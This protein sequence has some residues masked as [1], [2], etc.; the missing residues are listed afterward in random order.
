M[1]REKD[2][3]RRYVTFLN[4][5]NS[6]WRCNFCKHESGGGATRIKAHLAGIGGFGIKGCERV[7]VNVRAEARE[8]LMPKKV[9][10]LSDQG[11]SEERI[12]GNARAAPN[13]TSDP[14]N[15]E[16]GT[17][18]QFPQGVP[19]LTPQTR[20]WMEEMVQAVREVDIANLPLD[21][22]TS[23]TSA[24]NPPN[25]FF[26]NSPNQLLPSFTE[27][28]TLNAQ[29]NPSAPLP[30]QNRQLLD[31]T[32]QSELPASIMPGPIASDSQLTNMATT[33]TPQH[34]N[35]PDQSFHGQC[36][37]GTGLSPPWAS[38]EIEPPIPSQPFNG[39]LI[40]EPLNSPLQIPDD[41][42]D[43]VG[44]STSEVQAALV[45]PQNQSVPHQSINNETSNNAP[46]PSQIPTCGT[47]LIGPLSLLELDVNKSAPTTS[48]PNTGS[49]FEENGALKRKF[50]RLYNREYDIKNEL[51]YVASL[52][53]KKPRM[54]VANWLANVEKLRND[55]PCT[56]AASEDC[57]PPHRQVDILMREAEDLTRHGNFLSG[58]FEA[59]EIKVSKLLEGKMVG[60]AFKRN[61]TKILEYLVGNQVSRLGIYGMG[62]VGKTTIMVH[63]HN[64]LLE[65]AN[66]GNVLWITVS[67]DFNTQKLQDNIWDALSLGILRE[68]DV[69]KR[70][71][72]LSNYLTKRGKF[73]IILD[74][75]WERFDLEEVGIPV[76]ADGF[77]LVLTT[78]SFD[79]CCQM[80]CQEKIKIEPLSQKEAESLFLE[81]LGS[82]VTLNLENE[83]IVKSIVKEC[84]GLPLAV[85]TMAASMRGV[86]DVFEWKDYLVKLKESD[87]G[88][89]DMEKK[90]LMKLK[91]SYNRLGNHEVQ[92]CFLSCA[93]YPEDKLIDKFELIEFFIDQGLIGGLNTRERQYDR[94]LTILNK[95]E[96]V[97][98]LENYEK[99]VKMHDLIRDMALHIMSATSIVK[100]GKGLMRI[101]P[102][103]YW[104]DVLE[105][106]SLMHNDIREFPLSMSP[107]CPKL[108]TFLLNRSMSCDVVIL[109][110]FFKQLL[111]LK[112][113]NLSG[114][115]LRELPN[116]ISD[117]VNL[118]ALLLSH[119]SGL[120]RIPY[121]GNLRSLRKLDVNGCVCL[122]ALEG[123][124][125]LVNL[126]YL[127]LTDTRIKRLP[128]GT[129]GG[130]VN[131]QL[132]LVETVDLE[133]VTKLWPLEAFLCYFE[134]V[135]DFN[136]CVK[137]IKQ[138][139]P[140]RYMLGVDQEK[141]KFYVRVIDDARFWNRKSVEIH[142]WNHSIVSARRES[143]GI[144]ILIPQDVKN[145]TW[146]KCNGTS[147]LSDMG[148]LENLEKLKIEGCKNL[149]V[150][151]GGQGEEI[152]DIHDSP[153]PTPAPLLFPS[154]G[155]LKVSG[156]PKLKY[157]FGH[158]S[159]FYLPHL[160]KIAINDCE[161]MV[162]ITATVTSPSSYMLPAFP[163]LEE[164][165]VVGCDKMKRVVES[166][167]LPHFPNTRR[168]TV[169]NC[170][171]MEEII[172]GLPPYNPVEEISLESLVVN[173]CHNMRKLFPHELLIHLQNLQDIEV[174]YCKR[175]VEM[176]SRVEQ[177]QEGSI[178]TP[179]N[180]THSSY[181]FSI[182]LQ[183]KRFRLC[184]LPQLKSISEVPITCNSME[185]MKVSK[186]P[187]LNRIS[188]RLRL[189]DIEDLPYIW[190]EDEE[191][192]KTL[193]WDHPNAQAILQ[194]YLQK[195]EH[196]NE[197][198]FWGSSCSPNALV[199]S[200]KGKDLL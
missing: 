179:V 100:A 137:V 96:S 183:L 29:Q 110:S 85:I 33:N 39:P 112:V 117:L 193:M 198:L 46:P 52:S 157:L 60:E 105:K 197:R 92:Q 146:R 111:G 131:L 93:L 154:L 49:N 149:R 191:K 19:P 66:Y 128:K 148:M 48:L 70:A 143:T 18:L 43:T 42:I 122:E 156:C 177:G 40:F 27:P 56:K 22:A 75:V 31:N 99:E 24:S 25:S 101:P 150:L 89:T 44:P 5:N 9:M 34:S 104:T 8:V 167:W 175:M 162:G 15:V 186:C 63:I 38:M 82:E 139:S 61:T 21:G 6:K 169:I 47:G 171:N 168:I 159:I 36:G 23:Y 188:L 113:L 45:P 108:S 176:I 189:G 55:F 153:A 76:R 182:S 145:L 196:A 120:H 2:P 14:P 90:V 12:R 95:L 155:V 187:E 107:N 121:L 124:G 91:F 7:D 194:P 178:M 192:W 123:L 136:K 17:N 114:W 57:L 37:H 102:E 180:N 152:M 59:R 41:I 160:L 166:K 32:F 35:Q 77:K 129:L 164:I 161:E 106:V 86:T 10:D 184:D 127:D 53:L 73:I 78:R 68:K 170:E 116:S 141:L 165:I 138:S 119:C 115:D 135:D 84:P 26:P 13:S 103:E 151:C 199:L 51:K 88:Q 97:C 142:E 109:D 11:V 1:P 181:Q 132:L 54:E 81:E 69:R 125:M 67:Q 134:D 65:E 174:D 4:Q 118:R 190:V 62:G 83:G 3:F 74:D 173:C 20:G 163:S 144:C 158:G 98:L 80:H 64:R 30:S 94:G 126:R 172:E 58:L 87:M 140:H 147:N 72:M 16:G 71:A 50:K 28:L 133:D 200:A 130:L 195:V 79:V 185:F